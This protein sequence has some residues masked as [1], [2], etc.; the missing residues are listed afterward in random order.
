MD[1]MVNIVDVENKNLGVVSKREAHEKGL[2]HPC[3]VAM[4]HNSRGEWLLVRQ[5]A[6]RQDAGQ[7]VAPVGGHVQAGEDKDDAL[8]REAAEEVGFVDNFTFRYLGSGVF[9]R[10]VIGRHEN[11]LFLM[12]EIESD[13][14]PKLNHESESYRYFPE[15]ELKRLLQ[16]EPDLFGHACHF[17]IQSYFG[18]LLRPNT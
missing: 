7:Y 16:E 11:H 12:Y 1:E 17:S 5:A 4:I 10:H 15:D 3:V 13:A 2:L 6:D 8:R 18:H 14:V 9:D